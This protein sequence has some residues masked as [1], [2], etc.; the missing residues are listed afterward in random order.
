MSITI[1]TWGYWGW[2]NATSELI[3]A[4]DRV[5]ASRGYQPPFFVDTRLRRSGRARGF[6][7]D[8]FANSVGKARHTWM[9]QL[10]NQAIADRE[11]DMRIKN[12]AAAGELLGLALACAKR[13]QR[14]L[15]FCACETPGVEPEPRC[16][17]VRVASLLLKE[18]KQRN[19]DLEV[20]EWP[21]G[22]PENVIDVN[23]S[24]S[25]FV[26]IRKGRKSLDLGQKLPK[27]PFLSLPWGSPVK[28][29]SSDEQIVAIAN[30]ARCNGRGWFLPILE[31]AELSKMEELTKRSEGNRRH[32]GFLPRYPRRP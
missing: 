7:G 6:V 14:V 28:I 22:S 17:R 24:R 23:V 3:A 31:C 19:I 8:A 29:Q 11:L 5:E 10:G 12:P 21:G 13:R 16:H 20:V 27:V 18:A 2:G 1:F 9:Q 4:V 15:F 26:Q 32:Q 30:A 25:Q